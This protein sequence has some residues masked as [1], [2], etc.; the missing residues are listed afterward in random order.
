MEK[1]K[2][3]LKVFRQITGDV[4]EFRESRKVRVK[5]GADC[6]DFN[7]L[8]RSFHSFGDFQIVQVRGFE[9]LIMFFD[10]RHAKNF[11]LSLDGTLNVSFED[12]DEVDFVSLGKDEYFEMIHF[13]NSCG[14]I[15]DVRIQGQTFFVYFFDVRAARAAFCVVGKEKEETDRNLLELSF[16]SESTSPSPYLVNLSPST[17]T[18]NSFEEGHTKVSMDLNMF[19]IQL[20]RIITG[21]DSRTSLMIRNIPNKYTQSML[22]ELINKRFS[23]SFDYFHLPID[24]KVISP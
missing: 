7:E 8:L 20:D 13:L 11:M 1:S 12:C 5:V 14:E 2:K 19:K 15:S 23:N 17:S 22:L 10:I 4:W 18:E 24:L 3:R 9:I 21:E 16:V 6:K